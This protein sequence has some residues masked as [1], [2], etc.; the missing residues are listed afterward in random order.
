MEKCN[1]RFKSSFSRRWIFVSSRVIKK[2]KK[3][4]MLNVHWYYNHDIILV[5][6]GEIQNGEM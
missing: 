2:Q 6:C 5:K 3:V 1:V 4:S